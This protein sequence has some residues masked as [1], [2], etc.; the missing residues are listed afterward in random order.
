MVYDELTRRKFFALR[1]AAA[2]A[3]AAARVEKLC[4]KWLS[5]DAAILLV[6]SFSRGMRQRVASRVRC[7]MSPHPAQTSPHRLAQE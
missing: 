4:T 3:N 5:S 6:R 2:N 7:C 1:A